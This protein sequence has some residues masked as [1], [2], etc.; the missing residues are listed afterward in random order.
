ME[1][2]TPETF[3]RHTQRVRSPISSRRQR[4]LARLALACVAVTAASIALL[5]V[6]LTGL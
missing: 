3:A 4:R 5:A 2:Y 6:A 1:Q